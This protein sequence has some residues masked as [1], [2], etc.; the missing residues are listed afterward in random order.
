MNTC[1]RIEKKSK[2]REHLLVHQCLW[3]LCVP[4]TA[5]KHGRKRWIW[6]LSSWGEQKLTLIIN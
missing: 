4:G 1:K 5:L 2:D 6:S 3:A